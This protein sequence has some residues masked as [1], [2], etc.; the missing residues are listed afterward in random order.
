[1]AIVPAKKLAYGEKGGDD[2]EDESGVTTG[3]GT[4]G[5]GWF[6]LCYERNQQGSLDVGRRSLSS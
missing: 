2:D 1:M 3:R 6:S 4:A 5:V